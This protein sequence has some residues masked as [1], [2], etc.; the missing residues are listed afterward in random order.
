M[1]GFPG[2]VF[3]YFNIDIYDIL[4]IQTSNG[5]LVTIKIEEYEPSKSK[6]PQYIPDDEIIH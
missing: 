1:I 5:T 4:I 2:L 6:T 3:T